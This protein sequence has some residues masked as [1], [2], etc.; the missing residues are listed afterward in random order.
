MSCACGLKL[1]GCRFLCSFLSLKSSIAMSGVKE[2]VAQVSKTS[3][4]PTNSFEPHLHFFSG[5]STR[6]STGSCFS[7]ATIISLH[8]LQYQTGIGMPKCLCLEMFQFHFKP[9]IQFSY[10][11][12]ICSGYHFIFLPYFMKSSFRSR[13]F[14]NHW[15]TATY[16]I[17]VSH[18]SCVLTTCF[19]FS[20]FAIAS[21]FCRSSMTFF[22][23]SSLLIPVYRPDSS[24]YFPS[25]PIT[26][27]GLMLGCLCSHS[28][29][30]RLP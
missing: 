12:L 18:L 6:G 24:L 26:S 23:A 28:M 10:L 9:L 19:I 30:S 20:S 29:Q 4:S 21:S 15:S 16:S 14:M 11:A 7:S 5:L 25:S 8:F 27:T 17:S 3:F 22:L 2:E 13:Y 1:I